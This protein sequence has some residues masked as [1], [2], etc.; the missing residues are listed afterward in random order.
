MAP[1]KAAAAAPRFSASRFSAFAS[2][3]EEEEEHIIIP[4]ETPQEFFAR[5]QQEDPVLAAVA[6]GI[7]WFEAENGEDPAY[8]K[9]SQ[10]RIAAEMASYVPPPPRPEPSAPPA[11]EEQLE[12]HYMAYCQRTED[13]FWVQPFTQNLEERIP[14]Y[15]DTT[16]LTDDEFHAMLAWAYDKGWVVDVCGRDSVK[17][18]SDDG[19]RRC[20]VPED[21]WTVRK[22]VKTST[23]P[24]FCRAAGACTESDCRYVHE[25]T[26]PKV[27]RPCGFGAACGKRTQCLFM[28]PGEDWTPACCI[29]RH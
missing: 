5:L 4:A 28:H 8:I 2:D 12:A 19:P 1:K 21:F 27:N 6:R 17:L 9:E 23:I 20:Y 13:E 11:T 15:F 16:G 18:Q 24:R 10:A 14:D 7:S 25:D 22:P 3:S 26:I 29:H